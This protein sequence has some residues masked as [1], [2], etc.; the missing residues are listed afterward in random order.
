MSIPTLL[1]YLLIILAVLFVIFLIFRELNCWYWKINRIVELL[2][3]IHYKL[4]NNN[5]EEQIK[6]NIETIDTSVSSQSKIK[7][8]ILGIK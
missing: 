8:I 7:K 5:I 6:S 4:G 2:E 1:T 3:N